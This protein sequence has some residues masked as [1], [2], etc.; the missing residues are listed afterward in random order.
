MFSHNLYP[1]EKISLLACKDGQLSNLE[2]SL[3]LAKNEF[4][5]TQAALLLA[6]KE[7][8]VRINFNMYFHRLRK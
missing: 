6:N 2:S 3:K 1:Q 8:N 7:K 5:D 4:V